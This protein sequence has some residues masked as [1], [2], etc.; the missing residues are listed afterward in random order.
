MDEVI[1]IFAPSR[2]TV[3]TVKGWLENAGI[4][5]KRVSQSANKQWLQFDAYVKEVESLF[6]TKYHAYEHEATGKINFACDQ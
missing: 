1:D 6:H 4:S 5:G 3:D 2:N